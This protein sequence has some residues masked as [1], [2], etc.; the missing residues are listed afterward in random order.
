[1]IRSP[2]RVSWN[3]SRRVTIVERKAMPPDPP[4]KKGRKKKD[5]PPAEPAELHTWSI[6]G[7]PVG[8][9]PPMIPGMPNAGGV[10]MLQIRARLKPEQELELNKFVR[11]QR[12]M[13]KGH[14]WDIGP[15]MAWVEVR[16]AILFQDPDWGTWPGVA[17][18]NDVRTCPIAVNDLS[19]YG[20]RQHA[21]PGGVIT[22]C[23][24]GGGRGTRHAQQFAARRTRCRGNRPR[25]AVPAIRER[26]GD[27]ARGGRDGSF[28]DGDHVAG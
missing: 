15:N 11:G 26:L 18:P 21:A 19:A 24:A 16:D 28:A 13:V 17:D 2:I 20:F 23:D 27:P 7:F 1:M 4:K 5:E 25:R 3:C 12:V 9:A 6:L 14:L 22:D 8:Q 10:P